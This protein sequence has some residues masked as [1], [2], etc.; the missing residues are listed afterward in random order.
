MVQHFDHVFHHLTSATIKEHVP[1]TAQHGGKRQRG[2]MEATVINFFRKWSRTHSA[3]IFRKTPSKKGEIRV[4]K[5]GFL[6]PT[7]MA[8][9]TASAEYS[10]I[11]FPKDN[12]QWADSTSRV[13]EWGSDPAEQE[14]GK[15]WGVAWNL[16]GMDLEFLGKLQI[17]EV[18]SPDF[19]N[20]KNRHQKSFSCWTGFSMV[21]ETKK[22]LSERW[23]MTKSCQ[24]I[25]LVSRGS[26]L[27]EMLAMP[28]HETRPRNL[29][30]KHSENSQSNQ[31]GANEEDVKLCTP[32]GISSKDGWKGA[33]GK[34]SLKSGSLP[35]FAPIGSPN[36]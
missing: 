12:W 7:T 16:L 17:Y 26:T 21:G 20:W 2:L 10:M 24:E 27:D 30:C 34:S 15:H 3:I 23:K 6:K 11:D 1:P 4:W 36:P 14:K 29:D 28:D 35:A 18:P 19:I 33:C 8:G 22:Q 32:L 9:A 25:R 13:D 5:S 31:F